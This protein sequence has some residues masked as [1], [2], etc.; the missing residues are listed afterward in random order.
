MKHFGLSG[1]AFFKGGAGMDL[2]SVGGVG[3]GAYKH[4][5]G[6]S[7]RACVILPRVPGSLLS[8]SA[9]LEDSIPDSGPT[10]PFPNFQLLGIHCG[11]FPRICTIFGRV[12]VAQEPIF[13][14]THLCVCG[15]VCKFT[16]HRVDLRLH[17]LRLP[18][19][20]GSAG[21]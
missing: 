21:C 13:L 19:S 5:V 16:W 10:V 9:T 6:R 17:F 2:L 7:L 12:V 8:K 1:H 15:F 14:H 11:V 3:A 20:A 4:K 18:G